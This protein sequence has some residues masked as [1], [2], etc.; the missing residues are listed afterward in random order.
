ML[1]RMAVVR[2][3]PQF[4]TIVG[5]GVVALLGA[6]LVIASVGTAQSAVFSWREGRTLHLA[7]DPAAVPSGQRADRYVARTLTSAARSAPEST[8]RDEPGAA[9]R[10]APPPVAAVS[11]APAAA[12]PP[13]API[14]VAPTVVVRQGAPLITVVE[15]TPWTSGW[16]FLPSGFIG[17]EHPQIP[18][19]AGTRLAPHSH[20]FAHGRAG[21]FTPYGH[22]STH[23]VLVDAVPSW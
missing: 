1:P 6:T 11:S 13:A 10:R 8:E 18:F 2:S 21:R 23:G 14:I 17:H 3:Q 4:G 7:N 15:D 9:A 12:P 22:F 19:L 20:F 5:T 16:T